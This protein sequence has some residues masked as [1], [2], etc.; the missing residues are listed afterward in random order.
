MHSVN[1]PGVLGRSELIP[2]LR[3]SMSEIWHQSEA[4]RSGDPSPLEQSQ[5]LRTLLVRAIEQLNVSDAGSTRDH[6]YQVLRMQYVMGLNV[7]QAGTRLGI[8]EQ[9]VYRPSA[10][11]EEAVPDE[12]WHRQRV[13]VAPR[14]A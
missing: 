4:A 14:R 6:Q 1:N 11:G 13:L 5:L 2:P 12:L 9:G 7:V 3:E 8:A 10:E